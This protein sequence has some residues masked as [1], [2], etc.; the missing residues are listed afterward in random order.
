[1]LGGNFDRP[2]NMRVWQGSKDKSFMTAVYRS[3]AKDFWC[4]SMSID[5]YKKAMVNDRR[6]YSLYNS[7]I[8]CRHHHRYQ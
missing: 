1:M 6:S 4:C 7:P 8:A 3:Y 2:Q 5:R